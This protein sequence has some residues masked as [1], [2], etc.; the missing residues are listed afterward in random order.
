MNVPRLCY[1]KALTCRTEAR[2]RVV[3]GYVA[4]PLCDACTVNALLTRKGSILQNRLGEP[5]PTATEP[6]SVYGLVDPLPVVEAAEALVVSYP[7]LPPKNDHEV[8]IQRIRR[9]LGV[10]R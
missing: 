4:Y 8:R 2:N 9:A 7:D 5:N 3:V 10:T 1:G 6:N